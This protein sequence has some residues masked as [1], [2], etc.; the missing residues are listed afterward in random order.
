[1]RTGDLARDFTELYHESSVWTQTKW[2]GVQVCKYVS[3][4]WAYQ[5]II[6]ETRPTCIIETGSGCGGSAMFFADMMGE[7]STN[8]PPHVISVDLG[9]GYPM[10]D[11]VH[12]VNG[13][14]VNPETI[15]AVKKYTHESF[16]IMVVLDSDHSAAH[17]LAEM[18]AYGPL[19]S[20]GCYMVVEDTIAADIMPQLGCNPADAVRDYLVEHPEFEQ[21]RSREKFLFTS[22]PGGYLKRKAA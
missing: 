3:D 1:M 21:D 20:P 14:S 22:N 2:K 17:V 15:A 13:D 10:Y 16:R 19:V 9:S 7:L 6:W 11:G 5:E 18:R 8:R 12:F 4:L